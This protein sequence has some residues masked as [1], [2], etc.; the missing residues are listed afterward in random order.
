MLLVRPGGRGRSEHIA[1]ALQLYQRNRI[2]RRARIVLQST[3]NR[4]LFHL[5][6]EAAI[7]AEFAKRDQGKDRNNWLYSYNPLAVELT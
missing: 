4:R 7:R 6:S 5:H 3:D 1:A 2:D